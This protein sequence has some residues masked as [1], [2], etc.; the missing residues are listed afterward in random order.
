MFIWQVNSEI[1]E[2]E[3]LRTWFLLDSFFV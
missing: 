1:R 3:V 2:D